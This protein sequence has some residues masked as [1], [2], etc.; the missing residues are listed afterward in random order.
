MEHIKNIHP[1][2]CTINDKFIMRIYKYTISAKIKK[3]KNKRSFEVGTKAS[4]V[5]HQIKVGTFYCPD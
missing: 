5:R 2:I 4:T 1:Q 3:H